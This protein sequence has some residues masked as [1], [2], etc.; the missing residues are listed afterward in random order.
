M[1]LVEK[2]EVADSDLLKL[3]R[4]ESRR[5]KKDRYLRRPTEV[6]AGTVSAI[7]GNLPS[8]TPGTAHSIAPPGR[9]QKEFGRPERQLG[10][11]GVCDL[12]GAVANN[13]EGGSAVVIQGSSSSDLQRAPATEGSDV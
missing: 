11:P 10:R 6:L 7:R 5:P 2:E 1:L 3:E 12:R 9:T 13:Q 8:L 4:P